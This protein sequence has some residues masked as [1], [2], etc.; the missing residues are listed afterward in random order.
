[1]GGV[2]SDLLIPGRSPLRGDLEPTLPPPCVAVATV[3]MLAAIDASTR[4]LGSGTV[5]SEAS[6]GL[7]G[8]PATEFDAVLW[9]GIMSSQILCRAD[10]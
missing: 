10:T 2:D 7:A 4:L 1:M 6:F 3:P 8:T 9:L 5:A